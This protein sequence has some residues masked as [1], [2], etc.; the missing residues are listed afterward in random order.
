MIVDTSALLAVLFREDPAERILRSLLEAGWVGIGAPTLSEAGIV[1]HARTGL[2][3][4]IV[5]DFITRAE[6]TIIPFTNDHWREA[7]FA[8]E[9]Y[10]KGRH[11]AGFNFGD[12]LSYAVARVSGKPLI[13]TGGDFGKTDLQL[14]SY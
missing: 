11:P 1:F 10:G 13:C 3:E 4:S 7:V 9:K 2:S 5:S 14:V 8:F 12:C 6:L